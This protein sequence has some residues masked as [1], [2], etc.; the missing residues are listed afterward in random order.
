MKT[1]VLAVIYNI[2]APG[3]AARFGI[4]VE[5]AERERERFLDLYPTLKRRLEESAAYGSARGHAAVVSGLRRRREKT[6]R[7]DSWTHNFLRNTPIQGS[8]TIVFK[9][10]VIDLDR[11]FRGTSTWPVMPV[12]DAIVIECDLDQLDRVADR[13]GEI[14]RNALR[15][16]YPKLEARVDVNKSHPWCWNKDGHADSLERFLADPEYRIDAPRSNG[17]EREEPV[18]ESATE[19]G[20]VCDAQD[21]PALAFECDGA[22]Y[23]SYSALVALDNAAK[24]LLV[25]ETDSDPARVESSVAELAKIGQISNREARIALRAEL[26]L[27]R[28]RSEKDLTADV[29]AVLEEVVGELKPDA[30]LDGECLSSAFADVLDRTG[31]PSE[32]VISA[33]E[34]RIRDRVR[35]VESSQQSALRPHSELQDQNARGEKEKP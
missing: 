19:V 23:L 33:F 6:G 20:N 31:M 7:A 15:S 8:A 30:L 24:R 21:P 34:E 10:A 12:H 35:V 11:A 4:S 3:I 22:A 9:R 14:M 16:F 17:R 27:R 25:T 29:L 2:Q 5:H 32:Q 1:F 18:P 28:P 13:A 26:L